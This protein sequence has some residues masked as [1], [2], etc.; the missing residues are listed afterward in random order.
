MLDKP[1]G[2]KYWIDNADGTISLKE[3]AP[4][5]AKEEFEEYQK[6]IE[7]SGMPNEDGEITDY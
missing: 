7:K 4:E 3:D 5:W 2:Y 1:R 6:T